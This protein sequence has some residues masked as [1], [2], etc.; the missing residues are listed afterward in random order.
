MEKTCDFFFFE[1]EP[2]PKSASLEPRSIKL[3][4]EMVLKTLK[5]W[6]KYS[7]LC[8]LRCIISLSSAGW[9]KKL[10]RLRMSSAP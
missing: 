9:I 10:N 3:L 7:Y 1:N 2:K 5:K 6:L 4:I 8:L